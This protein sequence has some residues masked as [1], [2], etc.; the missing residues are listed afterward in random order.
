M[1]RDYWDDL[2]ELVA[3]V[4]QNKAEQ[5]IELIE[6]GNFDKSLLEDCWLLRASFALV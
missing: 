5:V 2:D 1:G 3:L 4:M 6:S